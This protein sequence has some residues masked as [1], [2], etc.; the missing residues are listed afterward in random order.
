[1]LFSLFII[2]HT[3][4]IIIQVQVI[5]IFPDNNQT[6]KFIRFCPMLPIP[7]QAVGIVHKILHFTY[8]INDKISAENRKLF[9]YRNHLLNQN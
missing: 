8:E 1:M 3:K 6:L 9:F 5:I 4:K 2:K 7:L